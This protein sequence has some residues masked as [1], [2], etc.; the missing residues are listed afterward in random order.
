[1]PFDGLADVL[2]DEIQEALDESMGID[3][4]DIELTLA[5]G[6]ASFS[7][8]EGFGGAPVDPDSSN[9]DLI[10]ADVQ[11][12][13]RFIYSPGDLD[14]LDISGTM[15]FHF[16]FMM[17]QDPPD[18][19]DPVE[20]YT[21]EYALQVHDRT[22]WRL[23]NVLDPCAMNAPG[24]PACDD[25][26]QHDGQYWDTTWYQDPSAPERLDW[27]DAAIQEQVLPPEQYPPT[28]CVATYLQRCSDA[29]AD[30]P[31]DLANAANHPNSL[32]HVC[33]RSRFHFPSVTVPP[34]AFP[35]IWAIG[36]GYSDL[37][38]IQGIINI[39]G[40]IRAALR[41]EGLWTV[42]R[43]GRTYHASCGL[44]EELRT[45]V[46][47]ALDRRPLQDIPS[48]DLPDPDWRDATFREIIAQSG[49]VRVS[50]TQQAID[51]LIP[52]VTLFTPAETG[53]SGKTSNYDGYETGSLAE[54]MS[55]AVDFPKVAQLVLGTD[56]TALDYDLHV[57][58]NHGLDCEASG[59]ADSDRDG[60]CDA[61]IGDDNSLHYDHCP[62]IV[63]GVN[64][65]HD[66]DGVGDGSTQLWALCLGDFDAHDDAEH[67]RQRRQ[68]FCGGC[69]NCEATP[70]PQTYN[71]AFDPSLHASD[72]KGL[73]AGVSLTSYQYDFDN[74]WLGDACDPDIDGDGVAN[75]WDC[76]SRNLCLGGDLDRDGICEGFTGAPACQP[77]PA[78]SFTDRCVDQC[79]FTGTMHGLDLN[80]FDLY[81][82]SDQCREDLDN[83]APQPGSDAACDDVRQTCADPNQ[84]MDDCDLAQAALCDARHANPLQEDTFGV[85]GVGD[86]CESGIAVDLVPSY[87]GGTTQ[88]GNASICQI[89]GEQY[90][91]QLNLYG[92][93]M[94]LDS[95]GNPVP[96][97]EHH[98]AVEVGACA[99]PESTDPN[100]ED[101][102]E[103]T[104]AREHCPSQNTERNGANEKAWNPVRTQE[105]GFQ[106][107]APGGA[108]QPLYP[109]FCPGGGHDCDLEHESAHDNL[110]AYG[111]QMPF[112]PDPAENS[113]DLT[114]YWP[115]ARQFPLYTNS[116]DYAHRLS[117]DLT[118]RIRAAWPDHG[119]GYPPEFYSSFVSYS[120][121]EEILVHYDPGCRDPRAF[122]PWWWVDHPIVIPVGRDPFDP[123]L[124][125]GPAAALLLGYASDLDAPVL[126]AL[127][128]PGLQVAQAWELS[129]P[130]PLDTGLRSS[131]VGRIAPDL[132][133]PGAGTA[134]DEAQLAMALYVREA[135]GTGAGGPS[136]GGSG[137]DDVA[138]GGARLLL[139]A[140][141]ADSTVTLQDLEARA[142]QPAPIVDEA[143]LLVLADRGQVL[144]VGRSPTG[145]VAPVAW[146]LELA[147]GQWQGPRALHTL[148]DRR[149]F[150]LLHDPLRDR[151][152]VF[153]GR[154]GGLATAQVA[155]GDV[156]VLDPDSLTRVPY[157]VQA[158][159]GLARSRAGVHLDPVSQ[160]LYVVGGL[161]DGS[162]LADGYVLD[163]RQRAWEP[164]SL[165]G[166]PAG[167]IEPFVYFQRRTG[168]LW[169][170]DLADRPADGS[171]ALW[172]RE[173][174]GSWAQVRA[175]LG[176]HAPDFPLQ[177]TY[178]PGRPAVHHVAAPAD[179]TWPGALLLASVT[180]PDGV[181]AVETQS[182][183][184]EP[185]STSWP[186]APGEQQAALLCAPGDSCRLTLRPGPGYNGQS[187][188]YT[189]DAGVAAL[190]PEED[191]VL[192]LPVRDMTLWEDAVVVATPAGVGLLDG[193]TR[194]WLGTLTGRGVA[195]GRGLSACGGFLCLSRLGMRGLV[196][197]DLSDPAHPA[198]RS[199]AFTAGLGW[200]VAARGRRVYVAHGIL[201]VGV[202]RLSERGALTYQGSVIPGGLVRSVAAIRDLVAAAR[203]G[204]TI[205]LYR[206][207][208]GLSPAGQ[209]QATGKVSR[210]RLV[211]GQLWVLS[212]KRDRL[213]IFDVTNPAAPTRLAALTAGAA[214][215]FR[216]RLGGPFAFTFSGHLLRVQR[217]ER[218]TP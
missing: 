37:P 27:L 120:T 31:N 177:D 38:P 114:W 212:K 192:P 163:L 43:F 13:Y 187:L 24:D 167:A 65:D 169:V 95:G 20:G 25:Y 44:Q 10:H 76:H 94:T 186:V 91:V 214:E 46:D 36:V 118:T 102:W 69:D 138:P 55:L 157:A 73:P 72:P 70:N 195:G 30:H 62:N 4:P 105:L 54:A 77:D 206:R 168:R 42:E 140:P 16:Y 189:L 85:E 172:A 56:A 153:G 79:I 144:L 135:P 213:E 75:D 83:C 106:V 82:C 110:L 6:G 209:V 47:G 160:K 53:C 52:A 143:Q 131:A 41:R 90:R 64:C 174:D 39:E 216:R 201:G 63:T 204:G 217:A 32:C 164:L 28:G 68:L 203:R 200:D 98:T 211:G 134:S 60:F 166:G 89:Y 12:D 67:E 92:G 199:R 86:R 34:D 23:L 115:E 18:A 154:S 122:D 15:H 81:V 145:Q 8:S 152:L 188:P 198:V 141:G 116:V 51:L 132:V 104:C 45:D 33:E 183:A 1:M 149:D 133:D 50:E 126:Y 139:G 57:V 194:Q 11:I 130:V 207:A 66:L 108:P 80:Y 123:L 87:G 29:V 100:D 178:L 2:R 96:V 3:N 180:S 159:A 184:G 49:G 22:A 158:P 202:Y 17:P 148:G 111:R 35:G 181:L 119:F 150:S 78:E 182:E 151:L 5:F 127:G 61:W 121:P 97:P 7:V 156:I 9:D 215:V 129:S 165:S 173:R 124:P 107:V 208:G 99:C 190:Q 58:C 128:Q 170:G 142:G 59:Y 161:R 193:A 147:T 179:A 14:L 146:R 21:C 93:D 210:V 171:V 175:P 196:V 112:S 103:D 40:R 137:D 71:G 176:V 205:H 218:V 101:G 26:I 117:N 84:P 88:A 136:A 19:V 191:R 185:R 113:V 109:V 162:V 74:D 155:L 125:D 48:D 197:L